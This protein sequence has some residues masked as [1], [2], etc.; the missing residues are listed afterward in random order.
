[1]IAIDGSSLF[2]VDS[3]RRS[4][5]T[6][7]VLPCDRPRACTLSTRLRRATASCRAGAGFASSPLQPC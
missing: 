3:S 2:P 4:A 7:S 1:M 5:R 6:R